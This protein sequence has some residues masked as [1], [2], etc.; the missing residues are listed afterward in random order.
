MGDGMK[1][2]ASLIL[3]LTGGI[4]AAQTPPDPAAGKALAAQLCA[5]CHVV[6]DGQRPAVPDGVAPFALIAK[7]FGDTP[8]ALRARL[9]KSPHPMMPE[10]PLSI[11]QAADVAAYILTLRP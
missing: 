2:L 7:K 4:A 8:E 10:P 11:G 3:L 1:K 5:N 6:S 9:A